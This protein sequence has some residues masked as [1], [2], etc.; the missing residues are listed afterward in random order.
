MH[1]YIYTKSNSFA[2]FLCR[3]Y[4]R[5]GIFEIDY[6]S[7]STVNAVMEVMSLSFTLLLIIF[8]YFL[9]S[10]IFHL[11][12]MIMKYGCRF[13]SFIRNLKLF[14]YL[15]GLLL[16]LL[17]LMKSFEYLL[18]WYLFLLVIVLTY[19]LKFFEFIKD[20][21]ELL[22]W[23]LFWFFVSLQKSTS[24]AKKQ[25]KYKNVFPNHIDFCQECVTSTSQP[26]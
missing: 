14:F 13:S 25:H 1:T 3:K 7:S 2:Y 15:V 24:T 9:K 11:F 22:V 18:A 6:C 10:V 26:I 21:I 4:R 20:I 5:R 23:E 16:P 8:D 12:V 17:M 19:H